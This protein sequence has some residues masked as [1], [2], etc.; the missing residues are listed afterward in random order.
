MSDKAVVPVSTGDFIVTDRRVVFRGDA[1]SFAFKLDKILDVA[2]FS[3]G[4]T[5]TAQSGRPKTVRFSSL[6]N[7]D[8]VGM[9][10]TH[11]VNNFG[12]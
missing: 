9:L 4:I 8:V 5:V 3:D 6:E 7:T 11:V 12:G 10:L 1:K 2:L